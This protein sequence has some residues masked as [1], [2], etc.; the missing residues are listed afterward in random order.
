MHVNVYACVR[1]RRK[2]REYEEVFA[3]LNLRQFSFIH[4]SA[5]FAAVVACRVP[6]WYDGI[7]YCY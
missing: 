2:K 4:A 5:H 7:D 3:N 6:L 1:R